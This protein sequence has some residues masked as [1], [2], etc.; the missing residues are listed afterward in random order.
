MFFGLGAFAPRVDAF[1]VSFGMIIRKRVG[2][3][4]FAICVAPCGFV[5]ATAGPAGGSWWGL[6]D[7]CTCVA[8]IALSLK[9]A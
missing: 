8:D 6:S 4:A 1:G 2:V 5:D 9:L 7:A 3:D